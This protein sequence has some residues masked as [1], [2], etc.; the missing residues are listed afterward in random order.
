MKSGF[1]YSLIAVAL[2][3]ADML[4]AQQ[5][6]DDIEKIIVTASRTAKANT[7]LALSVGSVSS[8]VIKNDNAQ[9]VSESLE[10]ISGVLLNQLSGGQGH[11]AAIRMPI[12]FGGYTLYLQDNVP[13]QSAAFYNHNALWW[14]STNSSLSRLEVVKG[15]GTSLYGSGAV[16]ATVNVISAPVSNENDNLAITLGE[17]GYQRLSGSVTHNISDTNGI[18]VSAAHLDNDGW[19]AHSS[20][21]KSEFNVLHEFQIDDKQSIKTSLI[22]STLDQQMLDALEEDELLQDPAQAGL[23]TEVLAIDPRR[24]TDY[25]RLSS[26]YTYEDNDFYASVI[27]YLRY[28]NNDY[29]ATW[30]PNM[31]KIESSVNSI[32]LLALTNFRHTTDF[33]TTI[34]ID[35]ERSEGDAYS[36]QPTTRTTTGW[37]AAT[38]PEGHVF[39]DDA[40]TFVGIS[41]YIQHLGKITERLNY[42]VGLRYDHNKYEFSNAV[43]VYD[44]DGFGNRSIA[45]RND[46]FEH[47]SPKASLNYQL[48]T[49]SSI[50]TRY[51]NAIRIPT[52][53]ELYHLKTKETSAQLSSLNEEVSDTYEIGYKANFD[54]VSVEL[55]YYVMDVKD[56]IV[57]AYDDFGSSLRVNA[58]E[59]QH[60]GFEFG[61]TYTL[62][63][64]WS[65]ALAYSQSNHKFDHYI[66]DEGRI[67]YKTKKSKEV[68]LSGNSLVMA[69]EYVANFR[70]NYN[71]QIISGL[72]IT[73][74]IKSIGDYWMDSE[75]S[76]EYSGYTIANLKANYQVND[77]LKV[78]ARV[79]NITDKTYAL[80][81]E[82]RYNRER[83]QPGSPRMAYIGLDY[84][85]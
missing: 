62:S 53:S 57:T 21:K 71:S 6:S 73:A 55:A 34:G 85:F 39:Y 8:E 28:R 13:L 40:T 20:V 72:N 64:A 25:V 63:P 29:I 45:S 52:F 26:E 60:Q 47:L 81:A 27:P 36:Y 49:H 77:A 19:R 48:N 10:T 83:I 66:Q 50:Y 56:A 82:I 69:P 59:V 84:S 14:A 46:T 54:K 70:L 74:E 75:N 32:G 24:T 43:P 61:T 33:E 31:P 4:Y 38:Y 1:S 11:N 16:A 5:Q 7:D 44:N 68:D 3:Q 78:H 42:A 35:L 76:Q 65:L 23:P 37:A 17:H 2:L 80:Q 22:S 67:D 58:A 51:A 79:A 41:P 15:A 9:H 12:N 18:R 30:Q